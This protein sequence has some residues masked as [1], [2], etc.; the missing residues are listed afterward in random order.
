MAA[1]SPP[2]AMLGADR[3]IRGSCTLRRALMIPGKH[4]LGN[5]LCRVGLVNLAKQLRTYA[6][7]RL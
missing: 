2:L 7:F 4:S 1:I 5:Y 3:Q 6:N